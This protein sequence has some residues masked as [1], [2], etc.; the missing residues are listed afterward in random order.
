MPGDALMRWEWEG[1]A[2]LLDRTMADD[3]AEH[4]EIV[5][6]AP[7]IARQQF[8]WD[9]DGAAASESKHEGRV[10]VGTAHTQEE[11]V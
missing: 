8:G 4:A 7:R 2:V 6:G 9:G 1:G 10:V 3:A 11:A 5:D